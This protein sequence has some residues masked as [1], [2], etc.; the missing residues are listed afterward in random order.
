MTLFGKFIIGI[1]V[2]AGLSAVGYFVT[3]VPEDMVEEKSVTVN[4]TPEVIPSGKKMAFSEF[5]KQGGAY[6]CTVSQSVENMDSKGT[7]YIAGDLVR[8]EFAAT[9]SGISMSTSFIVK[10]GYS[11]TWTSAAPTMGFKVKVQS[12]TD[13]EKNAGAS[14]S[15][16]WNAEQ[17]GDYNCESWVKDDSKF[18]LPATVTFTAIGQ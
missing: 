11:Y 7:V 18:V 1:I 3:K 8:G 5:I 14:G 12:K 16:S 4:E 17:I 2:V 9:V 10:E 6:K 15:Y 13:T